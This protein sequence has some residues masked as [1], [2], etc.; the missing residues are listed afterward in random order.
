[1]TPHSRFCFA[2]F[3]TGGVYFP[4]GWR[5]EDVAAH[6][7]VEHP[8]ADEAGVG[9]LMPGSAARDQRDLVLGPPGADND[10][11]VLG[12]ACTAPQHQRHVN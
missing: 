12:G 5:G 6:G 1:M 8:A 3:F 10:A 4:H 2:T 9:R 7:R 11:R